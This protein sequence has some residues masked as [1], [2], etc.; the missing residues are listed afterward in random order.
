MFESPTTTL[1]IFNEEMNDIMKII[2]CL[3]DY[4]YW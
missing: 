1:T 4:V 3:E 2:K